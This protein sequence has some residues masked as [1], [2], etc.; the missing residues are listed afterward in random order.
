MSNTRNETDI[1]EQKTF[2]TLNIQQALSANII[3]GFIAGIVCS[4]LFNPWD[5]AL[6]LSV[7][8]NRS[9]L[10][11]ENFI[12]PYQ[13]FSQAI[14][15]RAFLGSIYYILQG[16]LKQNLY[17]Y[18][19]DNLGFSKP[20]AQFC[21]GLS[22]GCMSGMLTNGISA[23]KYH[24]WGHESRTFFSS[25]NEMWYQGAYKPFFKG[26]MATVTRDMTF[27]AT[28]E[29]LRHVKPS[30][31]EK[32]KQQYPTSKTYIDFL[33]NG[34]SAGIATIASGPFNYARNMQY[35]TPPEVKSP[36]IAKSL[37]DLWIE[38]KKFHAFDRL[39]FFQQR[40]RIGWGTTRVI[41]GMAGGQEIFNRCKKKIEHFQTENKRL[42]K[43]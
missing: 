32:M 36:T 35:A 4:G 21:I 6:Y 14:I 24:T 20:V 43:K 11:K 33:F 34:V 16:E 13:G 38:S 9:F 3:S 8:Y 27:G 22:A 29:V 12:S 40:L 26:T 5:R 1:I 15:Q 39:G 2:S 7:K 19:H 30:F 28:Y 23:I 31:F 42:T 25:V 17:P 10:L 18:L 37:W 41:F